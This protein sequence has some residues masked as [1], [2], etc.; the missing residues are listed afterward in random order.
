MQKGTSSPARTFSAHGLLVGLLAL[1]ALT[2]P[3][4]AQAFFATPQG[5]G[6]V[7]V[8]DNGGAEVSIVNGDPV[9]TR[10]GDCP[11]HSYY[12]NDL[13]TDKAKLV[14]TDCATGDG[15]YEVEIVDAQ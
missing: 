15:T 7:V 2:A 8:T 9:G 4:S 6:S 12:F 10:P 3:V 5:D 13:D 14:L 1:P 11:A